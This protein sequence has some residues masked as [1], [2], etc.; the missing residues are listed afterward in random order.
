M[1]ILNIQLSSYIEKINFSNMNMTWINDYHLLHCKVVLK[2]W[3]PHQCLSYCLWSGVI[4]NLYHDSLFKHNW[5]HPQLLQHCSSTPSLTQSRISMI[6]GHNSS[7]IVSCES[8]ETSISSV[9]A[10][11]HCSEFS[12]WLLQNRDIHSQIFSLQNREQ[13]QQWW[14]SWSS[15]DEWSDQR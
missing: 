14:D 5:Y 12:F 1:T 8:E 11:N 6:C 7:S 2:Q 10:W 15:R 4:S 9:A 3:H 13:R